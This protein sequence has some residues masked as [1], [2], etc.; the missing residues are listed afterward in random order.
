MRLLLVEDDTEL[1][2]SLHARLKREGFAVDIAANGVDGE[3]M[4]DEEPYDVVILD[5]GLPQRSGLEVLQHWRQRGNRVPVIVLTA[6]DAWHERVDGF[7]AGADD[8]LGKPFHFEELLVRVQALIR[9]NLQASVPDQKL[10]CCG[11]QLDEEHQQVTTPEGTVFDLTGTE[12]RLLRYFMLHPGKILTKSRLTEHVYEQ[13]FDRDSNVIEVY[14]R[15]LRRKLGE[16]RIL[17]RRGQGYIFIDPAK[18][19]PPV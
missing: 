2:S 6:R 17:T 4:G 13:D 7:K 18:P 5:L 12:F 11:L 3:F 15:H 14:V 9:R 8:Y 19:E 1:S 10:D 16:W